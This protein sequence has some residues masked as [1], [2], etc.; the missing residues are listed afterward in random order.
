MEKLLEG[1]PVVI[2]I[3]V[4]WGEMDSL[5][6]V[7]NIVYFRYFESARMAYFNELAIWS[8][9]EETGIGPILASTRCKFRIPLAFP[10]TVSVGTK[11][12]GVEEDRFLMKY[13]VVSR[14]HGKVAAEGEGVIV[15]YDYREKKKA[16][17]P[18]E[19]KARIESLEKSV[20][21]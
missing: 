18:E 4:A 14:E 7:N 13:V 15:S 3:P 8:Y 6:H 16:P 12:E 19:I 11:V 2:E 17:L 1:Y 20:V 9:M 10:D 5:Q 21:I